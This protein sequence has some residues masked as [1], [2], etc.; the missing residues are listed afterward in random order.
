MIAITTVR[1]PGAAEVAR[2]VLAEAGIPVDVRRVGINPYFGT[3]TGLDIEVRVPAER[4]AEAEQ[5]LLHLSE[6]AGEALA[7][8]AALPL[9]PEA[10]RQIA[11]VREATPPA[12]PKSR[13]LGIL[14]GVFVPM[15]GPFY[16]GSPGLALASLL[17]H[18]PFLHGLLGGRHEL[19]ELAMS[20]WFIGRIIDVMGTQQAIA[21]Q[22][23]LFEK[24]PA[25]HEETHSSEGQGQ[26]QEEADHAPVS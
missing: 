23:E 3:L 14:F 12:H 11:A 15:L 17:I 1:D 22:N 2:Q 21:R 19:G 26:G 24:N 5:V 13:M 8:Q 25:A 7:G 6:A 20:S 18:L 4:L 9:D 10:E 16:A